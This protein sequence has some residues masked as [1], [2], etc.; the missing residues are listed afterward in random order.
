MSL[1][2]RF[3]FRIVCFL[4]LTTLLGG[5]FL[6]RPPA[7]V[8]AEAPTPT[9]VATLVPGDGNQPAW[10]APQPAAAPRFKAYQDIVLDYI[11]MTGRNEGW[12]LSG[13]TVLTT[14]NGGLNWRESSPPEAIPE[15][16]TAT[17]SGA[18]LDA[19]TAWIIYAIDGKIKFD[20]SVWHTTDGGRTWTSGLPLN[21]QVFGDRYWAEFSVLDSQV[22]WMMLRGVYE[23]TGLNY[24]HRLY[25]SMN[26][27]LTWDLMP[28]EVSDDYTGMVFT[29]ILFGLRTQR[30]TLPYDTVPPVYEITR[31]GGL[32]WEKHQLPAPPDDPDLFTRYAYC[33]TF[34]PVAL[35]YQSYRM[36]VGC[37]DNL[38]P[39][40][41]FE[42]YYYSSRNE[43]K[44]WLF[45]KLPQ[46]A[47]A[48]TGQLIFFD[49]K[50]VFLMGKDSFQ[51]SNNGMKWTYLKVVNWDGQF[52]FPDP[53][54]GWAIAR[55][56]KAVSLVK[57][58]N[59]A[60]TW[61]II[62]PKATR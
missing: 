10:P 52:S 59:R 38:N 46:K 36:L 53:Q 56:Q 39:H 37:Y 1:S 40:E 29:D 5:F 4:L 2:R 23:D 9:P 60:A 19:K 27:G 54:H 26:G 25:R 55:Y 24:D 51:S 13:Q 47:R 14:A 17:P 15:G 41:M 8:S 6:V 34:Q 61:K 28:S 58:T 7:P 48:D 35:S 43:G 33:E 30:S 16:S 12:A 44:T 42:G 3:P 11:K 45:G 18:F 32:T 20:A 62:L 22:L 31:D 57:T 49:E 21:H 50:N